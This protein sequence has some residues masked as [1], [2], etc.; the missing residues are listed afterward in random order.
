MGITFSGVPQ[1][2]SANLNPLM[3]T[4]NLTT[5]RL[6]DALKLHTAHRLES[7]ARWIVFVSLEI[8]FKGLKMAEALP[9]LLLN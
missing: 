5:V 4:A 1:Q 3:L 9:G 8:A 6:A 7:T 2:S